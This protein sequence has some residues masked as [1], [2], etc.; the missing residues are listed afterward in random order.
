MRR[1][2]ALAVVLVAALGACGHSGPRAGTVTKHDFTPA[3]DEW[4][5]GIVTPGHESCTMIGKSEDCTYIPGVNIP[6]HYDHYGDAW[7]LYMVNGKRHGWVDVPQSVYDGCPVGRWC[8]T[9][10]NP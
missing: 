5:A 3:H 2:A 6:G 4:V 10:P 7:S 1:L 8:N 9:R